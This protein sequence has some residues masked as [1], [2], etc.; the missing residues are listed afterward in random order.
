[1]SRELREQRSSQR[2]WSGFFSLL[3]QQYLAVS[4][5]HSFASTKIRKFN[6][7]VKLAITKLCELSPVLERLDSADK[8]NLTEYFKNIYEID[9]MLKECK[10][11]VDDLFKKIEEDIPTTDQTCRDK[12]ND[13]HILDLVNS[14]N[15]FL[16]DLQE[17]KDE[18]YGKVQN[19]LKELTEPN[20]KDLMGF[21]K[22]HEAK[23]DLL[24]ARLFA[25]VSID[26]SSEDS[27]EDEGQGT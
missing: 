23:L 19:R 13:R 12:D 26:D 27:S 24:T 5:P 15:K 4:D 14:M 2:E 16:R 3:S 21:M 18:Y 6:C 11:Q 9:D 8:D 17:K 22:V 7:V 25:E 10:N 20:Y 1:M